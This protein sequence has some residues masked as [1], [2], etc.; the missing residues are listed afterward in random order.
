MQ[1]QITATNILHDKV[2]TSFRLETSMQ[3]RQKRM[4]FP[5]GNQE[6]PLFRANALNLIVFNNK[7]LLQ[8]LNGIQSPRPLRL[9][10][11]NLTK[12]TLTQH[13]K[14]IEMI[15]SNTLACSSICVQW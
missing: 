4:S 1:H 15:K 13:S 8:H 10:Q 9:S 12:V 3:I 2:H 14:K 7:L 5:V 11:H 6:H